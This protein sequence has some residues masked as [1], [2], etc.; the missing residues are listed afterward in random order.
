MDT[1]R[2]MYDAIL[3]SPHYHYGDDGAAFPALNEENYENL[4]MVVPLGIVH[5]AQYLHDRGFNTRVVHL[6]H[7]Y[8]ALG[9][10]GVHEELVGNLAEKILKKYPARVCGV[11]VHWYLYSGGGVFISNLYKKLFPD[12]K[13]F[14]G[15]YM[16][17]ACWKEFLAVS[18]NIDGVVLGE[19]EKTFR[20]ILETLAAPG[21]G[22]LNKVDG[23]ALR[24]DGGDF[25]FNPPRPD[26]VPDMDDIPIIHPDAPP[27]SNLFWDKRQFI[28][29]SR[30]VCPEKCAY[31][32][33]NNK[34]INARAWRTVKIDRIIEQLHVYEAR[35]FRRIFLGEN[36]FLNV[37]LMSELVEAILGE[38]F[39]MLFELET[40]PVIF[41]DDALLEKMIR[42]NFVR[43][44]MG[45]ESGSDAVLK[46]MGRNSNTGQI[47][48]SVKRIA[49]RGGVVLTSWI[50]NL[51]GET[52]SEFRETRDL[53]PEVVRAGGLVY[54]IEN[55]HALPGSE[56][57]ENPEGYDIDILLNSPGEWMRWSVLSKSHVD[58]EAAR[59]DPL[60]YLT[61]LNR[62][63]TPGEMIERLHSLRKLARSLVPG[64]KRNLEN[65]SGALA[66]G[67]L[68]YEMTRLERYEKKG[69]RVLVI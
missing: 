4:T 45:C 65:R 6:P 22:D 58:F 50:C 47:L 13:V 59:A 18:E 54:W 62:N 44:T 55:L 2:F 28:N 64:M 11:Q 60:P 9:R 16:A 14:L 67:V 51:P 35:G 12:S 24:D 57:Y 27:F 56:L 48:D 40:H 31:C 61:H 10:V 1:E 38:N 5:V 36:H 33:G 21:S 66:P 23:L 7:E 3:I 46:R 63:A 37:S 32:V 41:E 19:G 68:K 15:G 30:G 49:E 8:Y 34:V 39:S 26:S 42:A 20:G 69:W 43:F 52:A 53:L 25:V 17:S 29:I